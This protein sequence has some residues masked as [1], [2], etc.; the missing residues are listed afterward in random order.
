MRSR[1]RKTKRHHRP[2]PL[3]IVSLIDVTMCLLL[4]FML[5]GSLTPPEG[6]LASMLK[7]Q[8]GAAT[9][10][11]DL[12]AQVLIVEPS[13]TGP[14]FR[15]GEWAVTEKTKLITVLARL[16]KQA[17]IVVR[18]SGEVPIEAA[19]TAL[20]ACKDAGF[21]RVSYVPAS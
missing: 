14:R 21:N 11:R 19:A 10:A 2:R 15:I 16:P 3:P 17:G 18:V 20:Q 5:A 8:T 13:S 1:K 6:E 7:A 4:Y 9:G 12:Q